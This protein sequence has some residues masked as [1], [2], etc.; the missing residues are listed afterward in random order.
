MERLT[1]IL[2]AEGLEYRVKPQMVETGAPNTALRFS[3]QADLLV[4]QG[5]WRGKLTATDAMT[6]LLSCNSWN[7]NHLHPTLTLMATHPD[8]SSTPTYAIAARRT[9]LITKGASRHQLGAFLVDT[10]GGIL[11]AFS[12]VEK[13]CRQAVTWE[14]PNV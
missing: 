8:N 3:L 6:A 12:S 7:R 13:D 10:Y 2:D 9:L 1:E 11:D 4:A 14:A 5:V